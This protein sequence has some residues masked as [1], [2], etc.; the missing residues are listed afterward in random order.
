MIQLKAGTIE[1]GGIGEYLLI[2]VLANIV[3]GFIVLTFWLSFH[4]IKPFKTMK[5]MIP[6]L[7]LAFFSKSSTGT[8]PVTMEMAEKN[9]GLNP[10]ISRF[11]LP[12]CTTLNMNGCAAFI[13]TTVIYLLQNNGSEITIFSM[14]SWIL[15]STIATVENRAFL[16][17]AFS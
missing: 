6:A 7:S 11:V 14:I 1:L 9:L 10:K 13:F 15:I 16:W 12:L 3:Q 4:K 5:G 2:I 17:D 8:L